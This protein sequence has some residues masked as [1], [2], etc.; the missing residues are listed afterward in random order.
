MT[1]GKATIAASE[2]QNK[3]RCRSPRCVTNNI[4]ADNETS[5]NNPTFTLVIMQTAVAIPATANTTRSRRVPPTN[6][7]RNTHTATASKHNSCGC[8]GSIA[9][10][11]RCHV[12]NRNPMPAINWDL[13]SRKIQAAASNATVIQI[14]SV[15]N[16]VTSCVTG[17]SVTRWNADASQK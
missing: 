5:K 8:P 15:L 16:R 17:Q 2:P 10:R 12:T 13:V 1:S 3:T 6:D 9:S 7:I 4:A 14:A 11:S